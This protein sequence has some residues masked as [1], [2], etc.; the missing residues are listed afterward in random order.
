MQIIRG[1]STKILFS[2][3]FSI[4]LCSYPLFTTTAETTI[5]TTIGKM[6]TFSHVEEIDYGPTSLPLV[7]DSQVFDDGTMVIRIVRRD[8]P[9]NNDCFI[10]ML[11]LRIINLDGTVIEKDYKNLDIPKINYCS[12]IKS[13]PLKYYLIRK[14]QILV[15][16]YN[17]TDPNDILN[18]TLTEWGIVI[19][20]DGNVLDR[21]YF[22]PAAPT[23]AISK[24]Q[25]NIN[26]EKGFLRCNMRANTTN[27][28]EW[29]QYRIEPE[30]NFTN[31]TFG[32]FN[33]SGPVNSTVVTMSTIDE[34]YA[35][36]FVDRTQKTDDDSNIKNITIIPQNQLSILPIGYSQ[37][38]VSPFLLYQIC[39]NLEFISL[40]CDIA[41]VG[42]GKVCFLVAKQDYSETA[43]YI[44]VNFLS[45]GAITSLLTLNSSD[46]VN[47]TS[48]W[49]VRSL[50]F[51]GYLFISF[52]V[53]FNSIDG[54]LYDGKVGT[55]YGF[56]SSTNSKGIFE[57][58][59]HNNT[60]LVAQKE[61]DN[62]WQFDI[63]DDL[64][65]SAGDRDKGYSNLNVES[66]I[67]KIQSTVKPNLDEVSITFY[68]PVAL[69]T[70]NDNRTVTGRILNSTFSVS[71][72]NYFI[73]VD[74]DFVRDRVFNEPMLG[75]RENI[76]NFTTEERI[77]HF[78]RSATGILRLTPG[79]TLYFDNLTSDHFFDNLLN[80]ISYA[81]PINRSRLSSNGRTQVDN[82]VNEKQYLISIDIKETRIENDISVATVIKYLDFMVRYKDQTPIGEGQTTQYLDE[83]YGFVRSPNLWEKYKFGLLGIFLF[84]G[85]LI[86]LFLFAQ[87]RDSR[88]NNIAILQLGIII[89][90]LVMDILFV[91]S[92]ARDIPIL[93]LPSVLFLVI[94][95]GIN[96]I[97]A[98]S[99]VTNENTNTKF[100]QWFKTNAKV[101]FLFTILAGADIKALNI[102]HSKFAG[103]SCFRAPFS[104]S[105]KVKILWGSCLSIF[106]ADI[107]QVA[108]QIYYMQKVYF[109]DTIPFLTLIF[110]TLNLTINIVSR[111]YHLTNR[112]IN[113]NA[114]NYHDSNDSNNSDDFD[115]F[116]AVVLPNSKKKIKKK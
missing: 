96:T 31:L 73:K 21:R 27:I 16:Y 89:L 23:S 2:L 69:S 51:G 88:G 94:P 55:A 9:P 70:E 103:F 74:N 5:E 8:S 10:N 83:K 48:F 35:I 75:I 113:Q 109:R 97:L 106:I 40:T 62:S 61:I 26:R 43:I 86:V 60:L 42:V 112:V 79:G 4:I 38:S 32:N 116:D 14:K 52:D 108:I 33:L 82:S 45:S 25:L 28:V 110:S 66:T 72:G 104:E 77:D 67:P 105:L 20:L 56:G 87:I 115:D 111:L 78:S 50:T 101:A 39:T 76:W 91:N 37:T 3:I 64:P 54:V 46:L 98:F 65:K 41:Y 58:L 68:D 92:N 17:S 7:Y 13:Y 63:T 71:K 81:V 34:G 24:I 36:V 80:E 47:T 59:P 102:L 114:S 57:I 93:Y 107:P 49:R 6:K 99:I 84:V 53:N 22:G 90:D 1:N 100:N 85:L 18:A 15:T 12:L 95:V 44:K 30:G 19:D 29:Q 11:S